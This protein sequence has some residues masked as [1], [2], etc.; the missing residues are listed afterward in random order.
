VR[1]IPLLTV[2]AMLHATAL[3][4]QAPRS[5]YAGEE[6]RAIKAL[7]DEEIAAYLNGDG[8]GFAK[9]AELN[10]Y[11]GPRHSLDMAQDLALTGAQRSAIT[12]IRDSMRAGAVRLGREIVARERALDSL[13]AARSINETELAARVSEIARL[14]GELRAVHL[15]AHLATTRVLTAHQ[16]ERYQAMRG[17]GESGGHR[18]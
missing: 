7:S 16:V 13:F 11:P 15:A 3:S 8:L 6:R 17:Y 10:R 1:A 5:P 4:A 12:A 18:H 14:Q 2:A 9:A